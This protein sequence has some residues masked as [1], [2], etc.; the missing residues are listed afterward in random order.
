LLLENLAMR[1]GHEN[2]NALEE[3]LEAFLKRKAVEFREMQSRLAKLAAAEGRLSN[4]IGAA[5]AALEGGDFESVFG[6]SGPEAEWQL[7]GDK[8]RKRTFDSH[9]CRTAKFDSSRGRSGSA[10]ASHRGLGT[11]RSVLP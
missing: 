8:K 4:L 5:N 2:P 10:V 9:E 6:L 1:F 3:N 11:R 7:S